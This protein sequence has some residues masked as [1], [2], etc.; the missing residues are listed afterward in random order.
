MKILIVASNNVHKS[1]APFVVEQANAL[2]TEGC[3]IEYFGVVGRGLLGYL[4]AFKDLK[5]KIRAY[6][7]D[8]IHAHYGLC[9]LLAN[10]Q[11]RVPVVTTYHGSDINKPNV[12][13][14]SKLNAKDRQFIIDKFTTETE[15]EAIY[16][17]F[18]ILAEDCCRAYD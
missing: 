18:L 2:C 13:K 16:P 6:Q 11:R 5:R 8:V 4:N 1:F 12:L 14:F 17:K 3:T 7:P 9:G 10:L 15:D